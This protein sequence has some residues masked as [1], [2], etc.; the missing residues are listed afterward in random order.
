MRHGGKFGTNLV[1][2]FTRMFRPDRELRLELISE[3]VFEEPPREQHRDYI[4]LIEA[5]YD[6]S[7]CEG[8]WLGRLVRAA[9]PVLNRG[10]GVAGF[11]WDL[12]HD[13]ELRIAHPTYVGCSPLLH[14]GLS[15][16][17]ARLTEAQAHTLYLRG[18]PCKLLGADARVRYP[19]AHAAY[20][21]HVDPPGF[22]YI[23]CAD[24]TLRGCTLL[25]PNESGSP[26]VPHLGRALDHI[27]RHVTSG[28]RLKR[29]LVASLE[30][31]DAILDEKGKLLHAASEVSGRRERGSFVTAA[32]RMLD[33]RRLRRARP[34]EAVELW[35]A[36]VLGRWSLVDHL[37]SDGKRFLVARRNPI[38]VHEPSA[39]SEGERRSSV[40]FALLGSV[41]L[42]AYEL[43]LAP[44]TISGELKS[45][46][47]K[48]GCRNRAELAAL[49][50]PRGTDEADED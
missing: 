46:C 33:S 22:T 8:V 44:S 25:V 14:D 16:S 28:L 6:L 32:R 7:G 49:L 48:L 9:H 34:T 42:V 3:P 47:R 26:A 38:G 39:L 37:D 12:S 21:A 45:A 20:R 19:R 18:R 4:G 23:S 2:Y 30:S 24:V 36:L 41:K 31:S 13:G 40:L 27:A 29:A 5:T 10:F 17:G 1:C 43:G 50:Q 11:L 35:R 15:D